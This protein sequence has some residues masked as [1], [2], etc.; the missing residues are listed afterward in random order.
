MVLGPY[1][2]YQVHYEFIISLGPTV[3]N[4]LPSGNQIST[5]SS[6]MLNN[7]TIVTGSVRPFWNLDTLYRVP[8]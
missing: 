7:V 5:I 8:R 6:A 4:E 2:I 3:S 1:P